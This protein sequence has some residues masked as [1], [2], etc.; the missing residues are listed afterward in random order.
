MLLSTAQSTAAMAGFCIQN[1]FDGSPPGGLTLETN[2]DE[3]LL[4]DNEA[5]LDEC[6]DCSDC[7]CCAY[8]A[9]IHLDITPHIQPEYALFVEYAPASESSS[10]RPLLRPPRV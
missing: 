3:T 5:H 8:F 6:L 7:H 9:L 2:G 4:D 1:G 10:Y